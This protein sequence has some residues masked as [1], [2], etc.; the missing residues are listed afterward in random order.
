[1]VEDCLY[2]NLFWII[3]DKKQ[4]GYAEYKYLL[5]PSC[6]G[7]VREERFKEWGKKILQAQGASLK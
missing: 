6:K 3:D 4:F 1:M 2:F 7:L 5:R